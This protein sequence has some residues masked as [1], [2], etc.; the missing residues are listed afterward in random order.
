M[1]GPRMYNYR[2]LSAFEP[3]NVSQLR[4]CITNSE[5]NIKRL[6]NKLK[7]RKSGDGIAVLK[8]GLKM[9]KLREDDK[10]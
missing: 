4:N 8:N 5:C 1:K 7:R 2:R 3:T 10:T 9:K 6:L